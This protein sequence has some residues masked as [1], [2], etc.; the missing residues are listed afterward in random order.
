MKIAP[1][2]Y[3]FKSSTE[4]G[5]S[6]FLREVTIIISKYNDTD[7][8][9]YQLLCT[10]YVYDKERID[11][12]LRKIIYLF[13]NL[14]LSVNRNGM[15]TDILNIADVQN[16]FLSMKIELLKNHNAPEFLEYIE[17]IEILFKNKENVI[18]YLSQDKMYGLLFNGLWQVKESTEYYSVTKEVSNVITIYYKKDNAIE[19][20]IFRDNMIIEATKINL[21]QQYELLWVGTK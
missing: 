16:R 17:Q 10:K 8:S 14:I 21:N 7:V 3:H 4:N 2:L 20:F 15:I 12:W 9:H 18:K 6:F 5:E 13:D 11:I 1:Q 19:E